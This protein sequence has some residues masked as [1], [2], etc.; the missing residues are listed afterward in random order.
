MAAFEFNSPKC[1]TQ[2]RQ[3]IGRLKALTAR[4]GIAF[5]SKRGIDTLW[6]KPVL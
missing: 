6:H 3:F 5:N 2:S 4:F 1:F